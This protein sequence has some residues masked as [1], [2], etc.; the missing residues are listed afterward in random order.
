MT[1]GKIGLNIDLKT[2][3]A[4]TMVNMII[5]FMS[6]LNLRKTNNLILPYGKRKRTVI[7]ICENANIVHSLIQSENE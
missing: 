6:A 5:L 3:S 1:N 4:I 2:V 7:A